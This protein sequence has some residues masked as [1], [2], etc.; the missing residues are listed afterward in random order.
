MY[1]RRE[2]HF[3]QSYRYWGLT[4]E[5][6]PYGLAQV[7]QLAGAVGLAGLVVDGRPLFSRSAIYLT[8]LPE[9]YSRGG[10]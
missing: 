3:H 2:T 1:G 8:V 9:T 5:Q 4:E 7:L 6:P 10:F